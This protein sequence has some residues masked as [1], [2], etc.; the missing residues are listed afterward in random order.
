MQQF[1]DRNE[2]C[3]QIVSDAGYGPRANGSNVMANLGNPFPGTIVSIEINT[4]NP[5][6]YA[7]VA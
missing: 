2:G 4:A 1:I 5:K 7:L 3:I 6:V